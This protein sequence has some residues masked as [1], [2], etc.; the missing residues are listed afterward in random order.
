MYKKQT[1]TKA[2]SK[3][4]KVKPLPEGLPRGSLFRLPT[5]RLTTLGDKLGLEGPKRG[6]NRSNGSKG[7]QLVNRVVFIGKNL[8]QW[9]GARR[10]PLYCP[11]PSWA[12]P[13]DWPGVQVKVT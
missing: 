7:K 5:P 2:I 8:G 12:T 10:A 13:V 4:R 6:Q 11:L 1:S 9:K 3:G